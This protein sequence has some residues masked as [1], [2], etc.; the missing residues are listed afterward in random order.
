[1]PQGTNR[2]RLGSAAETKSARFDRSQKK[3]EKSEEKRKEAER[4]LLCSGWL[5]LGLAG[6]VSE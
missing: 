3:K 5:R 4:L 6:R 1:M 2:E